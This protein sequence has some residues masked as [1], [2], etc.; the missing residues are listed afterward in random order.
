MRVIHPGSQ[1]QPAINWSRRRFLI[2][3]TAAGIT[4]ALVPLAAHAAFVGDEI[5]PSAPGW[6]GDGLGPPRYRIDGYAKATGAKLYARDFRAADMEGWPD[7]T[8]HAMLLLAADAT[9]RFL[10]IDLTMLAADLRPDKVVTAADLEAAGIRAKGYFTEDLMCRKGETPAYLG[11]PVALLIFRGLGKFVTARQILRGARGTIVFGE[12]TGPVTRPP[13]GA[14]RFTRIGGSDPSG[15]D[16]FSPVKNGWVVPPRFR[17]GQVPSWPEA[18]P[19]GD[20]ARGRIRQRHSCGACRRTS[21]PA[22]QTTLSDPVDR[23]LLHG[24]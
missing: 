14:N 8:D 23:S 12:Q 18:D 4:L 1:T 9:H 2:G 19:A 3:S 22:V 10:G 17:R 21:G 20:T 16:E 7:E 6:S 24:A 15:P 13:Y 11:Q 5:M